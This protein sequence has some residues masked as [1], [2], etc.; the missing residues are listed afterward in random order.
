MK[1]FLLAS[2]IASVTA[3]VE[4]P[5]TQYVGTVMSESA[6][7]AEGALR[8][9]LF[10]RD[11]SSFSGVMEL[12]AP[13]VGTGS[14]YVWHEGAELRA[15]SIGAESGD[16]ILWVSPLT[17]EGLGGRFEVVGGVRTGDQGTWRARLLK[18]QPATPETLLLPT[19]LPLPPATALWPLLVLAA[20]GVWLARWIRRAPK[21]SDDDGVGPRTAPWQDSGVGGWLLLFTIGQT[22]GTL[23]G[24]AG[25]PT[26]LGDLAD[27][28]G[29]GAVVIGLQ[30][31]VVLEAAMHTLA[32][33]ITIAGLV[34]LVRHSPYT[35]RYWF[36]YLA[37]SSAYLVVDLLALSLIEP[38]M[39]RLLGTEM[40]QEG[41]DGTRRTL[42]TQLIASVIW[43]SYWVR[44]RRVRATFGAA[45]LDRSVTA[46]APAMG[47][48]D[49][50]PPVR[51]GRRWRRVVLRTAG[52]VV[53][54]LVVL[55]AIGLWSSR[56]SHYSVP[57]DAD[58]RETVAGRWTWS[59]DS[60]G[61]RNAHTIA[62]A[63][64]GGVMTIASN[65][66]GTADPVT[67]Y[68][69]GFA[70]RSTIRGTIRGET[71][72]TSEGVPVVW[73]LVLTGPDEYRWQR[74][75]LPGSYTVGIHRCPDLADGAW[76]AD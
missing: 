1:R 29:V 19:P 52:G 14:A 24:L 53:A 32:I 42:V 11:D 20:G 44:S 45:A 7:E 48:V 67:T 54:I 22:I 65:D 50:E 72:M 43:A 38:Q 3:C 15:V 12:G 28:V 49:A 59:S 5:A 27:S 34:L 37:A 56:V 55:Y 18:G 70:S 6:P 26:N 47:V 69:V 41:M 25:L 64:D 21:A 58:I 13:A 33:P 10:S 51:D 46:P 36:A 62:F 60:A 31:L 16:T 2:L 8:L 73:D 68:D 57:E 30:P 66:I 40:M 76:E 4:S 17:D 61:C 9:T 71:R 23:V 63:E 75:D 35:P 74:A 39:V